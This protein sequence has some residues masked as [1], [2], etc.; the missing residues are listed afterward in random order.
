MTVCAL[1]A[2]ISCLGA[3]LH[4]DS[5]S[6]TEN[7]YINMFLFRFYFTRFHFEKNTLEQHD[8]ANE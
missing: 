2:N 5:H 4:S 3:Y 1:H 7:D 6:N 8:F